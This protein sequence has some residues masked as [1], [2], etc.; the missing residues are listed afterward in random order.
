M[1]ETD[2]R[3]DAK[4]AKLALA[5]SAWRILGILLTAL[6]FAY[7]TYALML[8]GASVAAYFTSAELI[9]FILLGGFLYGL[10]LQFVGMGWWQVLVSLGNRTLDLD[11]AL[12][13]FGRTQI[14][15]YLPTNVLHMAG[16]IA[17][18]RLHG[19]ST[20]ILIIAQFV[21]FFL[22]ASA[23]ALVSGAFGWQLIKEQ[24]HLS[25]ISP[26]TIFW[27][28]TLIGVL[29]VAG[30]RW[31]RHRYPISKIRLSQANGALALLCYSLFFLLNGALLKL[32]SVAVHGLDIS[33]I[34]LMGIG[35]A[36]WL[37]GFIVPGAPG[38]LGV[39]EAAMIAALTKLGVNEP[40][41]LTLA[42]SHRIS[43]ILGD[44]AV[45]LVFLSFKR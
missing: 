38:G 1:T 17:E 22:L 32:L 36:A 2:K 30:M 21:E 27:A 19:V 3:P 35:A 29:C 43:T 40:A 8:S 16:R 28:I 7:I 39:R 6:A 9:F 26:T 10:T 45:A 12:A 37:I 15:K 20:T 24:G 14:Y 42:L 18:A 13:I 33:V 44:G 34:Q 5:K 23:A 4:Q 25:S 41:A 31:A 11:T